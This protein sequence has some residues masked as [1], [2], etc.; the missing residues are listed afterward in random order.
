[1]PVSMLEKRRPPGLA[2][3][4][5]IPS[6]SGIRLRPVLSNVDLEPIALSI[7]SYTI[8]TAADCDVRIVADGIAARHCMLVIGRKRN[9]IRAYSPLTWINE[10]AVG[11]AQLRVG[12][13]LILGPAEF[14]VEPLRQDSVS[15][16][17]PAHFSPPGIDELIKQAV[18]SATRGSQAGHSHREQLVQEM[19][20]DVQSMIDELLKTR[21]QNDAEFSSRT[22]ALQTAEAQIAE[23][24]ATIAQQRKEVTL[25][26]NAIRTT[27]EKLQRIEDARTQLE[28]VRS[29]VEQ[30][31]ADNAN[32]ARDL[33][34]ARR[35]LSAQQDELAERHR[36]LHKEQQRI[37][38]TREELEQKRLEVADLETRAQ[39]LDEREKL[40]QRS[41][42]EVQQQR[43]QLEKV[44]EETLERAC[45]LQHREQAVAK[46]LRDLEEREQT[47]K[48]E[49]DTCQSRQLQISL[50][51]AEL[52]REQATLEENRQANE[53]RQGELTRREEELRSRLTAIKS[54]QRQLAAELRQHQLDRDHFAV[55]TDQQQ[56]TLLAE[57]HR[58]VTLAQSIQLK[59]DEL[60]E[61]QQ[62]QQQRAEELNQRAKELTEK[63]ETI[64]SQKRDMEAAWNALHAE[65]AALQQERRELETQT[66]QEREAVSRERS[67]LEQQSAELTAGLHQLESERA[68]VRRQQEQVERDR[69]RLTAQEY[70]LKQAVRDLEQKRVA[71][72]EHESALAAREVQLDNERTQLEDA[73]QAVEREQAKCAA[74]AADLSR[75]EESLATDIEHQHSTLIQEHHREVEQLQA[76]LAK[77][78]QAAQD[79]QTLSEVQQQA[80]QAQRAELE[81]KEAELSA[82]KN[83]L[84]QEWQ[85]LQTRQS[86]VTE[87]LS[88]I[89]TR[90]AHVSEREAELDER[91]RQL[92]EEESLLRL[93]RKRLDERLSAVED[94]ETE[95]TRIDELMQELHARQASLEQWQRELESREQE[96]A[97]ELAEEIESRE[98]E[99]SDRQ[100]ALDQ[101]EQQLTA[102]ATEELSTLVAERDRLQTLVDELLVQVEGIDVLRQDLDKLSEDNRSLEEQLQL[103]QAEFDSDKV[104]ELHDELTAA[105]QQ[106]V[107]VSGE[108]DRLASLVEDLQ[109]DRQRLETWDSELSAMAESLQ[110]DR[111]QLEADRKEFQRERSDFRQQ[112]EILHSEPTQEEIDRYLLMDDSAD[113]T[114]EVRDSGPAEGFAAADEAASLEPEDQ[115]EPKSVEGPLV[116]DSRSSEPVVNESPASEN[117]PVTQSS[118]QGS[119]DF[120]A[121]AVAPLDESKLDEA[122]TSN[123]TA[124]SDES[125][126]VIG[127]RAELANIFGIKSAASGSSGDSERQRVEA[128]YGNEDVASDEHSLGEEEQFPEEVRAESMEETPE[129]AVDAPPVA[130]T[131]PVAADSSQ[132]S[133]DQDVQQYIQRLLA[134]RNESPVISTSDVESTD[135]SEFAPGEDAA[136]DT[137]SASV[138]EHQG[139]MIVDGDGPHVD[140]V[141]TTAKPRK[142]VPVHKD[143]LRA[144]IDSFRDVANHS[145][146]TA[147]A[148]STISRERNIFRVL[149]IISITAWT[150]ALGLFSLE[151]WTSYQFRSTALITAALAMLM[152][153]KMLLSL[154]TIQ[155]L[156]AADKATS[157]EDK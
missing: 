133:S 87:S 149:T 41:V 68:I 138:P 120:E 43:R 106:L 114:E 109:S 70:E 56:K 46:Q 125:D 12:D 67:M 88:Q 16:L 102:R 44:G 115:E 63:T 89:E 105:Q 126:P 73:R 131:K 134:D 55:Q 75:R 147:L 140:H 47:L 119:E 113:R 137:E 65:Q 81:S 97:R 22:T 23:Q 19:I 54:H 18:W 2:Q 33:E 20:T 35:A 30:R 29:E 66:Q 26:L 124:D 153:G 100:A 154:V 42:E 76:A 11:E 69:A 141:E 135:E 49:I 7:G 132:W 24:Q 51:E 72:Q 155:R 4:A 14:I 146:R 99:F 101:R 48:S 91:Q 59:A 108:C 10:G 121:P 61:Q 31:A 32:Q 6:N 77:Q 40:L 3:P 83:Q 94:V 117:E 21:Q 57:E 110:Q 36:Q 34:A 52:D 39:E 64:Q 45:A 123:S 156:Q 157:S 129:D 15:E 139:S 107:D 79:S 130:H 74:Q 143:A 50:R 148:K 38:H 95:Q 93:D 58:L 9:L 5:D 142:L 37:E 116:E 111:L 98:Q 28:A 82:R 122:D 103:S 112:L 13:R 1:M 53:Q 84:E 86:A 85:E 80:F 151:F 104:A 127:L 152:N 25:Q 62:S 96:R 71:L 27:R 8:G 136:S 90:T 128:E 150:I 60:A 78:Q 118:E 92:A 145:A 17:P 144:S